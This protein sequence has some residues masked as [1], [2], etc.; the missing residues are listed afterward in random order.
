MAKTKTTREM[1]EEERDA[2]RRLNEEL[3]KKLGERK[4]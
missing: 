2:L 1:T 3:T 4:S